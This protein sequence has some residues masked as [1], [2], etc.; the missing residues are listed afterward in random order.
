MNLTHVVLRHRSQPEVELEILFRQLTDPVPSMWK[1]GYHWQVEAYEFGMEQ[2][3]VA[4]G[5]VLDVSVYEPDLE[6]VRVF[7]DYQDEDIAH[8]VIEA[9]RLRWPNLDIESAVSQEGN[10][11]IAS[12]RAMTVSKWSVVDTRELLS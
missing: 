3:P 9:A 7:S 6:C 12:Y 11:W 1:S 2:P 5:W 4:I 10:G 8:A